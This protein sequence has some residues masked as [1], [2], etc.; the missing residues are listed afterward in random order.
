MSTVQKLN[1]NSGI[2][3]KLIRAVIDQLGLDESDLQAEHCTLSDIARHGIGGGYGG[4]TYY[5][6]TLDFWNKNKIEIRSLVY[7]MAESLGEDPL[8]MIANFGC[9]RSLDLDLDQIARCLYTDEETEY[10]TQI[11]NALSWFAGEEIA[12]AYDDMKESKG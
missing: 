7:S 3:E 11:L 12:R 8:S 4:F 5:S 9:L 1:I 10:K 6:D 2:S